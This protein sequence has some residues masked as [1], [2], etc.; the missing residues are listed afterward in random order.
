VRALLLEDFAG[1]KKVQECGLLALG[2]AALLRTM[3]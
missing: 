2:Y 1:S 3:K